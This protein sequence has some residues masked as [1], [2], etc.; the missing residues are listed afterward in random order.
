MFPL[1]DLTKDEVRAHATRMGLVTAEKPESMEVCFI[2]D[3]DHARFVKEHRPD[4]DGAG[5][6]VDAQGQVL[7]E[8]DGYFRF[9]IGQRR[10][11]NVALGRPVYVTRIE[12][13]TRRVVVGF[14]DDLMHGGLKADRANWFRRPE[15]DEVVMVRLRHRGKL[16]P[17]RVRESAP[18]EPLFVDFLEEARAVAPGQAAV[19]Y[20]GDTVLGGAWIRRS[21]P[22]TNGRAAS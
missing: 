21:M 4:A 17:C 5:E 3:D 9:T 13:E 6:I 12:P 8:H 14:A 7:G 15:P 22:A 16:V 2:P 10:G 18:E 1:G 20:D 11:L 19:F